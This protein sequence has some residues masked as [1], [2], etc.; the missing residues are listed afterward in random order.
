LH[1]DIAVWSALPVCHICLPEIVNGGF[2]GALTI[3]FI[4]GF[5]DC[6]VVGCCKIWTTWRQAESFMSWLVHCMNKNTAK[7]ELW[8][9]LHWE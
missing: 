7:S 1:K 5:V 8:P 9:S 3:V 6:Q 2:F 4:L